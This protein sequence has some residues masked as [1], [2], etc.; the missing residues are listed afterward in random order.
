MT[1][2]YTYPADRGGE[3]QRVALIENQEQPSVLEYVRSIPTFLS[4]GTTNLPKPIG[5][6]T[7][8]CPGSSRRDEQGNP[9]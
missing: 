6:D 5:A 8:V 1:Q 2:G 7:K 9:I 4:N 3:I